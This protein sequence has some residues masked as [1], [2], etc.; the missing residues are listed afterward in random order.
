MGRGPVV[1]RR[2]N[3]THAQKQKIFSMHSKI[4]TLIASKGGGDP[5]KNPELAEAIWKAKKDNVPYE[6]IKRAIE[7]ATWK[8]QGEWV[9]E[10]VYEWYGVGGVGII[11]TCITDNKNR[12]TSQVRSIFSKYGGNM[13]EIGS[14]S[15][16]F[17]KKGIILVSIEGKSPHFVE[18]LENDILECNIDDYM[19]ESSTVKV[20]VSIENFFST[21]TIL[22]Q[23]GYEITSDGISY[24][25]LSYVLVTDFQ[26]ALKLM[27]MFDAFE[28]DEDIKDIA[29]NAEI[30]SDIQNQVRE[31]ME[32]H[33]I[34][35]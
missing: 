3:A 32:K 23:K 12:T 30:P 26:Q 1:E 10:V 11:V 28:D 14:V 19:I 24:I 5:E 27:K 2:K 34:H 9:M 22:K 7:R 8:H 21:K 13:G 6:N 35:F 17:E 18:M 20:I 15:Y 31:Y 29:T 25:P 4:I 16:L 33:T